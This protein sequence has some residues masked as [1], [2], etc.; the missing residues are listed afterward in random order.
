[1]ATSNPLRQLPA[2]ATV[3][4]SPANSVAIPSAGST[5]HSIA[6]M[7]LILEEITS[8]PRT[9]NA[10]IVAQLRQGYVRADAGKARQL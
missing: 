6:R 2:E 3:I 9:V 1:M 8:V 4:P 7:Q 5:G 10:G